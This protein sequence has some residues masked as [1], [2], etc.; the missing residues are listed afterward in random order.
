[1]ETQKEGLSV[2]EQVEIPQEEKTLLD[3]FL[4]AF[5]DLIVRFT[6]RKKTAGEDVHDFEA[7]VKTENVD[8]FLLE[9]CE[10][11]DDKEVVRRMCAFIDRRDENLR[12]LENA[13]E[14]E[15]LSSGEW[16]KK[17]LVAQAQGEEAEVEELIEAVLD[18]EILENA[19]D[20]EVKEVY[21]ELTKE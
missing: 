6:G 21:N 12:S 9:Q 13:Q 11:E 8:H 17:K 10:D 1:M 20:K 4:T 16:M 14:E 18:A 15:D 3:F 2:M 19:A 5:H 7:F